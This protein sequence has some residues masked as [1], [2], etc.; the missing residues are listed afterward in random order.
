MIDLKWSCS[1]KPYHDRSQIDLASNAQPMM[2]NL[3]FKAVSFSVLPHSP[4][5]A[6]VFLAL[7]RVPKLSQS[8]TFHAPLGSSESPRSCRRTAAR[9]SSSFQCQDS[10]ES[11]GSGPRQ[12]TVVETVDVKACKHMQ[13]TLA[14]QYQ[15]SGNEAIHSCIF[16]SQP[17]TM[18]NSQA[19]NFLLQ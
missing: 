2:F 1:Q 7:K 4:S 6:R 19:M 18:W 11:R 9:P 12:L 3:L 17:P 16:K 8:E 5:R 14:L 15:G 10:P 13:T